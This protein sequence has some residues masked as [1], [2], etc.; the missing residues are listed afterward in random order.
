MSW[1]LMPN[2]LPRAVKYM[3]T[4]NY[5]DSNRTITE[6]FQIEEGHIFCA[7]LFYPSFPVARFVYELAFANFF[8]P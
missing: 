8:L 5:F 3:S 4:G 7:Y 1:H 6:Y 2:I